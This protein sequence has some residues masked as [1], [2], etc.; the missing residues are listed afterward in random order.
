LPQI[1]LPKGGGAIRGMDEKVS[2]EA[3]GTATLAIQLPVSPGRQG[4]APQLTLTYNSSLGNG[5]LG[6]GW[7]L[8]LPSVTRKTSRGLP[9]YH[10]AVDADYPD[11]YVLSGADDLVPLLAQSAGGCGSRL[12]RRQ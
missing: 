2:V 6:L 8:S 9:R 5:P 1:S 10:D 12:A 4:F 7:S 3:T 11:T